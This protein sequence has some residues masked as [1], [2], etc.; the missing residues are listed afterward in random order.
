[1]EQVSVKYVTQGI[2]VS[3][4]HLKHHLVLEVLIVWQGQVN[5]RRVQ[6]VLTVLNIHLYRSHVQVEHTLYQELFNA[7][8]AHLVIFVFKEHPYKRNAPLELIQ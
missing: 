4:E 8:H 1:M 5:A 3:L 2:I 6:Q 7:L